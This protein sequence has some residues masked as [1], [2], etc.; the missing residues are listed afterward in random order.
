MP[1]EKP[2]NDTMEP[3]R[4]FEILIG[5]KGAAAPRWRR[6]DRTA[7]D[8]PWVPVLAETLLKMEFELSESSTDLRGFSE[9]V[10]GDVGATIQILRLAGQEYG[11]AINRPV[12]VEDCISDLGPR[13]CLNAAAR[14][15]LLGG[16][17][18][19]TTS[20]FW[21]HSR[22]VAQYFRLFAMQV[23]S[24]ISPDQAYLAGLLHGL[25]ALPAVLAWGRYGT[26]SDP[27]RAALEMTGR[28]HFPRFVRDFF[29]EVL[30]PGNCPE[31]SN[32]I[33]VAHHPAKESWVECPLFAKPLV[34]FS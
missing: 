16:M 33:T 21:E 25:G 23:P 3:A 14:G 12:R 29:Y 6:Q 34:A 19:R 8:L 27:A 4:K 10:L 1:I 20:A 11:A 31:W 5:R 32:F 26:S 17:R 30:M 28:W 22:E 2:G 13:A 24:D 15:S 9:A 18:Q 7:E